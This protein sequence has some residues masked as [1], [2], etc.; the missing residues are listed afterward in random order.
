LQRIVTPNR[1]RSR[2]FASLLAAAALGGCGSEPSGTVPV[3]CKEGPGALQRA[4]VSV[5]GEVRLGGTRVSDCF[6]RAS[7]P[8]D[9]QA[10][11]LT[12]LP[13]VERL[14]VQVRLHPRGPAALRLG[15]LIAAVHRGAER[16]QGIYSELEHRLDGELAGT[17]TSSPS[18]RRGERAGRDH[19]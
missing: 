12:F 8:G 3:A 6:P 1:G 16:G 18:Y 4:L 13:A 11:G 7:D 9:V 15:F 10:L 17:D 19:G 14:A 2:A 5:P